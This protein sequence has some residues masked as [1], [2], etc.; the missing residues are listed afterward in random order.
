MDSG[1]VIRAYTEEDSPVLSAIIRENLL[2]VNSKDYPQEIIDRMCAIFTPKHITELS[3]TRT[4]VVAVVDNQVIGTASLA[5]DTIYTV[6]VDPRHHARGYGQCLIA[7]LEQLAAESGILSLQ[8]P[9]SITA[10]GFYEKLGYRAV[11][12]GHSEAFGDSI[13]MLKELQPK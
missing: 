13:V 11:H 5:G 6:F 12:I 3:G 1:L 10:Q 4:A 7:Y 9:S 2:Q 8:L